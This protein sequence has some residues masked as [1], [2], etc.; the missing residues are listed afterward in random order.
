[1]AGI[2]AASELEVYPSTLHP[3]F[4]SV[5]L[6][7]GMLVG[8]GLTPEA[9]ET[10]PVVYDLMMENVWRGTEGVQ[11]LNAWIAA[12]VGRRYYGTK[13]TECLVFTSFANLIEFKLIAL[14]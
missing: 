3:F 9:I 4:S 2:G 11:D 7:S 5:L 6:S 12:Y 8:L 10:N 13:P 1:M 14:V